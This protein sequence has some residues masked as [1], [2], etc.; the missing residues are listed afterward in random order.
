MFVGGIMRKTM[1][2][3]TALILLILIGSL[4]V[5]CKR[6]NTTEDL[7]GYTFALRGD[8]Y[9]IIGFNGTKTEIILPTEYEGK[10]ITIIGDSAFYQ[11][12]VTKVT[13]SDS[14]KTVADYAF[15]VC[16]SLKTIYLSKSVTTIGDNAFV[17]CWSLSNIEVAED[18]PRFSSLEGHLYNKD[19]TTLIAY[20]MAKGLLDF[21]MPETVT[22]LANFVF[23][24]NR[25]LKELYIPASLKQ[26]GESVF[27]ESS[28]D[29]FYVDE[30]NNFFSAID[31]VL[32]SDEGKT[33]FAF[34]PSKII[35]EDTYIISPNIKKINNNAFVYSS[36]ENY[37]ISQGVEEIGDSVF[38]RS[39]IKTISI[40]S[41]VKKIGVA[42]FKN[43]GYLVDIN[44]DNNNQYYQDIGGNLYNKSGTLFKQ[45]AY[46]KD[47]LHCELDEG[48]V[49]IEEFAFYNSA[50]LQDIILP[51]TV[52][53]IG[54]SALN[55][56][57]LASITFNS[58][59]PPSINEDT[60][61]MNR[62][63]M[64]IFVPDN[65]GEV[66][67]NYNAIWEVYKNI[68]KEFSDK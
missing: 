60:I 56:S 65:K 28:I 9:A 29:N 14:I 22:K 59:I 33:L 58:A 34:P 45:Y 39:N 48:V 20:S 5:A 62:S 31:G 37:I 8:E 27:V 53:K 67:K 46:G 10:P 35:E 32:Y 21:H 25:Y 61:G 44:V 36:I 49:E 13:I 23:Y 63:D 68:I 43:C 26:I 18:N 7:Q 41:T 16:S 64:S 3:V 11:S 38:E 19:K 12:N 24:K 6:K 47:S 1:A 51:S 30:E 42:I 15:A 40:S 57:M 2:M 52:S 4:L 55:S 17:E 54:Y 50:K 66:Y